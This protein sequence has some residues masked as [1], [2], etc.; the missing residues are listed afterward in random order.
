MGYLKDKRIEIFKDT[1]DTCCTNKKLIN[2]INYSIINQRLFLAND[3]ID[4]KTSNIR[5]GGVVVSSK[6]T[7]EASENYAKQ[8][9]KVCV[10]NFASAR[11][12][13]GGVKN[14]SNAQEESICRCSTLYPCLNTDEMYY[15]FY[16]RHRQLK[17][18]LYNDDC[19]Y[20]PSIKVIKTDTKL[21]ELLEEDQWWDVDVI[22]CAAPN[23][24]S[25]HE[26]ANVSNDELR[27]IYNNRF[28]RIFEL[29]VMN[30]VDILILG[31]F[32]CGCFKNDPKLVADVFAKLT[33]R[34]SKC[35][36]VV[37]YAVPFTNN[38]KNNYLAF[39]LTFSTY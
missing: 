11:N 26:I 22:T 18:T 36:D 24:S 33:K 27:V 15:N 6:R 3:V 12:P 30:G 8:G 20:T 21:P 25:T 28:S 4:C 16:K 37:E 32:G 2:S 14:G 34:Y 17:G 39:K 10:L 1:I 13:G 7:L 9:K 31:A 19:I 38:D 23:L 29:A 5:N 35:F